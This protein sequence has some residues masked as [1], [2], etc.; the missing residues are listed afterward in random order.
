ME[1]RN[2]FLDG[3]WERIHEKE[4]AARIYE[5]VEQPRA[6]RFG[7]LGLL[8]R[9]SVS[10]LMFGMW[11]VLAVSFMAAVLLIFMLVRLSGSHGQNMDALAFIGAPFFYG[12][13]FVLGWQKERQSMAYG[14][15]MSCKYTFFHVLAARMLFCSLLGMGFNLAYV[16]VLALK[17]EGDHVRL[18]ALSFSALMI[19]SLLLA[20]GLKL[21]RR[22]V[23]AV[24]LG[25]LWIIVN[26]VGMIWL[27]EGYRRLMVKL[28]L[29]LVV[30]VG[31][32]AAAFYGYVLHGLTA[33][34]FRKGY[35][36]A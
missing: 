12:I 15:E 3:V 10:E 34:T 14:L 31:I 27:P 18:F 33:R 29:W 16:L 21:G 11:D 30:F 19:F 5:A 23:W 8:G 4:Q 20:A 35:L 25:G 28:P 7:I 2:E 26:L 17:Y 13:I 22:F 36:D 9:F 1:K 24:V 32:A 6:V